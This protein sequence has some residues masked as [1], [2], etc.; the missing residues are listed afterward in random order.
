MKRNPSA[1]S[2]AAEIVK[3]SGEDN[4]QQIELWIEAIEE[5]LLAERRGYHL[6]PLRSA[7]PQRRI[8]RERTDG[9]RMPERAKYVGR[10][11]LWGNPLRVGDVIPDLGI[12]VTDRNILILYDRHVDICILE[13]R[14]WLD[15]LFGLDL[16]CWCDLDEGCHADVLITRCAMAERDELARV[17][18]GIQEMAC[19]DMREDRFVPEGMTWTIEAD[20]RATLKRFGYPYDF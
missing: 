17:L 3:R 6:A 18:G 4:P 7:G 11:T 14:H 20:A 12:E 19:N 9:W 5:A 16:A 8:K 15:P 10:K 13:D 2:I 1:R